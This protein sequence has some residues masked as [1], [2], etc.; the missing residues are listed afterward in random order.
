MSSSYKD[1]VAS[2]QRYL[3]LKRQFGGG[4][5]ATDGG[6]SYRATK[7][8]MWTGVG[9]NN[10]KESGRDKVYFILERLTADNLF[11]WQAYNEEQSRQTR[12]MGVRDGA[13]TITLED[14]LGSFEKC[15]N[16]FNISK[17]HSAPFDLWIAYA[18]RLENLARARSSSCFNNNDVEMAFCVFSSKD[19]PITTH[20]GIARN[21]KYFGDT[22]GY[23]SHR[24]LSM[25]LHGFAATASQLVYGNEGQKKLYMAT[26]PAHQMRKIME[27]A[28]M[29]AAALKGISVDK[30][31]NVGNDKTRHAVIEKKRLLGQ[32]LS[33]LEAVTAE[34]FEVEKINGLAQHSKDWIL[35]YRA[36][37]IL[38]DK[39]AE[40]IK[41][42]FLKDVHNS[43]GYYETF[44][45]KEG[46]R[47]SSLEERSFLDDTE[48]GESATWK[49]NVEGRE[50][51][52]FQRPGWFAHPHMNNHLPMVM[53]DLEILSSLF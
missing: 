37:R 45:D 28:V 21:Y 20:M 17:H 6:N 53:V 7:E 38:P 19:S 51:V 48:D 8:M 18:C 26:R 34:G 5:V 13:K 52:P 33:Y 12:R 4:V 31:L 27:A 50:P 2:K 11:P 29:N 41:N 39:K 24:N 47:P 1:Y 3:Q 46:L 32:D 25:A 44:A 15:L 49:I 14:G 22:E 42:E 16:M 43:I 35:K 9:P 40:F 30:V 10:I 23:R 36:N